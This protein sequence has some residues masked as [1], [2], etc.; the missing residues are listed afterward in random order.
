VR[1]L[2]ICN[3]ISGGGR[4]RRLGSRL[5][6]LLEDKGHQ[7]DLYLTERAGD[8]NRRAAAIDG[9]VER[10][11]A[12]GGDGT[13][14]EVLNGLPDPSRIPMTQLATGTANLLAHDLGLPY[15]SEGASRLLENGEVRRLDMGMIGE[16]RFLMV[17]SSGFDAMVTHEVQGNRTG[18]MSYARWLPSIVK[19]LKD[20][21]P[22]RLKVEV[23]DRDPIEGEMVIVSNVRPYAGLF[24]VAD[25]ARCH[26]GH[27]DVCV[28]TRASFPH[29]ARATVGG[30]TGG[31]SQQNGVVYVTG[32]RIALMAQ[33]PVPVQLDGEAFGTTPLEITLKPRHVPVVVPRS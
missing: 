17:V 31:L 16:K 13:L 26:S 10:V 7:V 15:D 4:S 25:R 32:S 19:L 8:A 5:G 27:L 9:D 33:D 18:T 14:N 28:L 21:R 20:Y 2:I 12:V 24:T 23:D 1:V 29:L 30:L 11:V 22:P 6:K 3:P